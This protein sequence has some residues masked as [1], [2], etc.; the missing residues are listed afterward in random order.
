MIT[1]TPARTRTEQSLKSITH[2]SAATTSDP[3]L[4]KTSQGTNGHTR[5]NFGMYVDGV[6]ELVPG[7]E[8]S[9]T[10]GATGSTIGTVSFRHGFVKMGME[11][12]TTEYPV[13]NEQPYGC[14]SLE[15]D[16]GSVVADVNNMAVGM[17]LEGSTV[18][19]S[20]CLDMRA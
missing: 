12:Y 4:F 2:G 5:D 11:T 6:G 20:N 13:V 14:F 9:K 7:T 16:S 15:G 8:I 1:R 3:M 10:G 17:V 19:G 18:T